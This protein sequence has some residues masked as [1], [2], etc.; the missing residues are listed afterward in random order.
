MMHRL[1]ALS[2]ALALALAAF[3]AR[4]LAAE[5]VGGGACVLGI[6]AGA[7]APP[8]IA[9]L[10]EGRETRPVIFDT[11]YPVSA[12]E[13]SSDRQSL[14]GGRGRFGCEVQRAERTLLDWE[15]DLLEIL[16]PAWRGEALLHQ[17]EVGPAIEAFAAGLPDPRSVLWLRQAARNVPGAVAPSLAKALA[18]R[19]RSRAE[20]A[21]APLGSLISA[22]PALAR[23]AVQIALEA[24]HRELRPR[25]LLLAGEEAA[26]L[27][28]GSPASLAAKELTERIEKALSGRDPA[29]RA[30][31]AAALLVA[32]P[33][34]SGTIPL[35]AAALARE[36]DPEARA[37][38]FSALAEAGGIEEILRQA[39]SAS[40]ERRRE[41]LWALADAPGRPT[42]KDDPLLRILRD[43]GADPSE[44]VRRLARRPGAI[45]AVWL[46]HL[47]RIYPS[48]GSAERALVPPLL[49]R[50]LLAGETEGTSVL[51]EM[52]RGEKS[53]EAAAALAA[54][55][56]ACGAGD[57]EAALATLLPMVSDAG[58]EEAVRGA[59]ARAA[60][61][62]VASADQYERV[63]EL[64]RALLSRADLPARRVAL[65]GLLHLARKDLYRPAL[66]LADVALREE[67]N[68]LGRT[69][70]EGLG[71]LFDL[72]PGPV[73]TAL[74]QTG[75][76]LPES[77]QEKIFA[78]YARLKPEKRD[79]ILQRWK[80][81]LQVPGARIAPGMRS[82]M[83][84][85]A[86]YWPR[87]ILELLVPYF[88]AAPEEDRLALLELLVALG[89]HLPDQ[90][91]NLLAVPEGASPRFR[92]AVEE[93][94][95][96]TLGR[97]VLAAGGAGREELM[98]LALDCA[99]AAMRTRGRRALWLLA[100]ENPA[101]R[102]FLVQWAR[103]QRAKSPCPLRVELGRWLGMVSEMAT[104]KIPVWPEESLEPRTV[105]YPPDTSGDS[106]PAPSAPP[107]RD[108]GT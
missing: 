19:D 15:A 1:L 38:L 22:H 45:D 51:R 56:G 107:G 33:D 67:G 103:S 29:A 3:P 106:A 90:V 5:A 75:K 11:G 16:S 60:A 20:S 70:R 74:R 18:S 8:R 49:C 31:A 54:A 63:F 93:A 64:M 76:T 61:D 42:G 10:G 101:V 96:A 73:T 88:A 2:P 84:A 102:P 12:V 91:L 105:R 95:A 36:K 46:P 6:L 98:R 97:R 94:T 13:K 62:L 25:V 4:P 104:T 72:G 89:R 35:L 40:G 53:P 66:L 26:G 83:L 7:G 30:A 92:A 55:L 80:A 65:G 87:E 14:A 23:E 27:R 32:E 50:A 9:L 48:L 41:A 24:R 44:V 28:A 85:L 17:G 100:R 81:S 39:R 82:E 57:R 108:G 69:A 34:P 78:L 52:L 79:R 43:E 68:D 59:A 47:E 86:D 77:D 58:G 71:E 99:D 37:A 21:L